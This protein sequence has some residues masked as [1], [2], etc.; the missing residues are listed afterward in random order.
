MYFCSYSETCLIVCLFFEVSKNFF[1]V[2]LFRFLA[3]K[4]FIQTVRSGRTDNDACLTKNK[5]HWRFDSH[6]ILDD[7]PPE[8]HAGVRQLFPL[9]LFFGNFQFIY[10]FFVCIK[11][12]LRSENCF[13]CPNHKIC[14]SFNICFIICRCSFPAQRTLYFTIFEKGG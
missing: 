9:L 6:P 13:Y 5:D 8:N 2:D 4:Y 3:S 1:V 11:S 14:F 12:I 7:C 10:L